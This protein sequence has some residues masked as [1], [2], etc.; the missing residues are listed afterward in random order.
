M[1]HI[2]DE[3]QRSLDLLHSELFPKIATGETILFLGAG[4]SVGEKH[5][6][7]NE[8]MQLYSA[9]HGL[10]LR[11][12]D[13]TEFLDVLS[14]DPSFDR[15]E[16]DQFVVDLLEKLDVAETHRILAAQN[17]RE[18]ITTNCDLVIEKAF[19]N[20]LG[21]RSQ[22]FRIRPI[23]KSSDYNYNKARDEIR[24]V[25]LGGCISDKRAYPLIFS[26]K[27]FESSKRFYRSVLQSLDNLSP[28]IRFLSIG[29][30]FSDPFAKRL[31]QRF[32]SY[33]FR[34]RNWM[35]S[36][37]PFVQDSQLAYFKEKRVRVIRMSAENFLQEYGR[38][39]ESYNRD[40]AK[41]KRV[42]YRD[43]KKNMVPIPFQLAVRVS[44]NLIQ[45]SDSTI[46]PRIGAKEFYQGVEP[47]F[48]VIRKDIDVAK[49]AVIDKIKSEILATAEQKHL[50]IPIV[51]LKG[52][53]GIGK[54]TCS[55]RV[56]YEIMQD[57]SLNALGFEI[58]E[59]HRL[60]TA[61]IIEVL[62]LMDASNF[63]FVFNR[64]EHDSSFKAL[65]D[66]RYRLSV[67]Q[68]SH[69]N[70]V[71]LTSIRENILQKYKLNHDFPNF[72]EI[73]VEKG[74]NV[75][76]AS[77]LVE[78]LSESGL[79]A[80]RD[81]KTKNEIVSQVVGEY[82]GDTFISLISLVTNSSHI[83]ILRDA[84]NQ[85][86]TIAREAFLFTSLL[87][88]FGIL[89]PS[90]LLQK[91]VSKDWDVFTKEVLEYDSK[92]IIIQEVKEGTGSDP[93][94][95]L[96]TKHRIISDFLVKMLLP[97][98]DLRFNAYRKL[99][100]QLSSGPFNSRLLVDLLESIRLTNDLS[101]EK[102]NKLYEDCSQE[103][104]DDP[105]FILHYALNLQHRRREPDLVKAIEKILYVESQL[106][107]RSH[108][109]IHRRAV[110]NFELAK[111][112]F[113]RERELVET[114]R[115]VKEAR[116]LF[117]IKLILDPFT[118]YSYLD[119]LRMEI[120][121]LDKFILDEITSLQQRVKIESLFDQAEQAVY[122][123]LSKVTNLH[124]QFLR[125]HY[126][127]DGNEY[128]LYLESLYKKEELRPYALILKY[129]LYERKKQ[130]DV[131]EEIVKELIPHSYLDDVA[132]V[133]FKHYGRN[134]HVINNRSLLFEILKSNPSLRKRDPVRYHYYS[135]IAESYNRNF[136]YSFEQVTELRS[137]LHN[138]NPNLHEVWKDE[139]GT[140]IIFKGIIQRSGNRSPKIRVTDLQQ[141]FG[142]KRGNYSDL[143][144]SNDAQQ[145]VSLHFF[146][147]GIR[148]EIVKGAQQESNS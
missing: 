106:D 99:A 116:D 107:R 136:A 58:M 65:L 60:S 147:T 66:F 45:L 22:N 75:E 133:L 140:P 64:I 142:L 84:Y 6:L 17:W 57:P 56:I 134:L 63:L 91:L 103:F 26:S 59:A 85:L 128:I 19:D 28:Q 14:A 53:Y 2:L 55:Y 132:L 35:H 115:Y 7:S 124:A 49:R 25:K 102:I 80:Y 120:W 112:A 104:S 9:K 3:S 46:L 12:S 114:A 36:V 50:I 47:T 23:K 111:A 72:I 69:G 88:R 54:S 148:A 146:V 4:A 121:Y 67:E 43:L 13:I 90:T 82:T 108:I 144:V 98:E 27:D 97:D 138:I 44:D 48:E 68:I 31:L 125:A 70:I 11:S 62:E 87:Y 129:Y 139:K 61:D 77:Q 143:D 127:E 92:G 118:H 21:T 74:F 83:D 110:L 16:F 100:R 20:I 117:E 81:A 94:L 40:L 1:D 145:M 119:Y 126:G 33:N 52:G 113:F 39:V 42:V 137:V 130:T 15:E 41:R 79:L 32:D 101:P 29:Y 96:R 95:V 71:I 131:L 8:L 5:F 122:E 105:H 34:N 123:N 78:K 86:G 10:T 89:M 135:Y 38:W 93:D 30:S 18:I 141:Q 24:Y 37:D 109:L 51:L 73:D 76:E